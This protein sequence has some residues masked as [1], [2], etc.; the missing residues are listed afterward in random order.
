VNEV[1]WKFKVDVLETGGMTEMPKGANV[2]SV[3]VQGDDIT[4]WAMVDPGA[5]LV[6]RDIKVMGTG[7]PQA[8]SCCG[9]AFVGTVFLGAYVFHVFDRGEA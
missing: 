1:I 9:Y 2:I 5:P 4:V 6:I 8:V 3:G 7:D